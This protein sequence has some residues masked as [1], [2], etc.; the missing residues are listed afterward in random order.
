MPNQPLPFKLNDV[1]LLRL[2]REAAADTAR[3]FITKHAKQRMRER[4]ITPTQVHD[5]LRRGNVSEPAHATAK[6]DWQCSITWRNAGDEITVVT[7]LMR[8]ENGDW[9]VVVT[10]F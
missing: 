3:V 8:D 5:C 6:G 4:K 1:N 2:I 9:V 10:V 7:V